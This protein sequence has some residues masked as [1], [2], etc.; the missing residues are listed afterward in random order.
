MKQPKH[1]GTETKRRLEEELVEKQQVERELVIVERQLEHL[2]ERQLA[3]RPYLE[4]RKPKQQEMQLKLQPLKRRLYKEIGSEQS[5]M[6]EREF[7]LLEHLEA[8]NEEAEPLEL[9]HKA[10]EVVWA[11]MLEQLQLKHYQQRDCGNPKWQRLKLS[12]LLQELMVNLC[13]VEVWNI[14]LHHCTWWG[15]REN[16]NW[17]DLS[18]S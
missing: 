13:S 4:K 11:P 16:R 17:S 18:E 5:L 7:D 6:I 12:W 14:V 10:P 8:M 1:L 9:E 2:V 15:Q 3:E